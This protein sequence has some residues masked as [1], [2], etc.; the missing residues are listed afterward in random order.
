LNVAHARFISHPTFLRPGF[1]VHHPLSTG[2][3]AAVV[4]LCQALGWLPAEALC[5]APLPD[6][7][8]LAAF[9]DRAYL[10]ALERASRARLATADDRA[11][12]NLGTMECPVFDGLWER[13]QASV[14]G[15]ILAAELAL[16]GVVAFH[17]AGGTH[18][19]RAGRAA[20][21]CYLNDPVF[22]IRRL[23]DGGLRQV[24]YV[25]LDAHHGDGVE[26]AFAAEKRVALFSIHEAGRWPRTGLDGARDGGRITNVVAKRGVG[27]AGFQALCE[28]HLNTWLDQYAGTAVVITVG[29][30]AL[31]GDPLS[32]MG[33]SN[34]TLLGIVERVVGAA[35]HAVVLGGGGYNP[36]T[37]ARLWAALW[38]RLIGQRA[39][40][41]LPKAAQTVLAA[42]DSDLVDAEDRLA[43]WYTLL[44]DPLTSGS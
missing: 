7:E 13:A 10:A 22:A 19:G 11:R 31:A 34:G 38:G 41:P 29:A 28:V 1:G 23:L 14:G 9:H 39:P 5:E 8:A 15:S 6:V 12:F 43:H 33:L 24:A 20:G 42:L 18:H 3:Q 30:D 26:A 25:D 16:E 17:P 32:T 4:Q 36:W 40:A 44:D 27:D 21:F 37:T 2:R 35:R